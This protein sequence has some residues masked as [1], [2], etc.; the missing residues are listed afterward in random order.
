LLRDD[1][2][3]DEL[4]LKH[5]INVAGHLATVTLTGFTAKKAG[6]SRSGAALRRGPAAGGE[7]A[8]A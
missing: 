1:E 6:S 2:A 8:A 7:A 3:A 4:L 5:F